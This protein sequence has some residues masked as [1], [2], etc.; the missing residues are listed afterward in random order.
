MFQKKFLIISSLI[1]VT[2]I[3]CKWF[4]SSR[5]A[6]TVSVKQGSVSTL[7]TFSVGINK[8]NDKVIKSADLINGDQNFKIGNA[9]FADVQVR[10]FQSEISFRAKSKAE[11]NITAKEKEG[12]KELILF[13]KAGEVV[14]S[15]K[16]LNKAENIIVYTPTTK[17]QVRGTQFK[18]VV[19]EDATTS[20]KVGEGAVEVGKANPALE[21]AL[22]S[23]EIGEKTKDK[24][25]QAM[26]KTQVIEAGKETTVTSKE[27]KDAL[28]D[29]EIQALLNSPTLKNVQSPTDTV[30][31][32]QLAK[33]LAELENKLPES[34]AVAD[35]KPAV[36]IEDSKDKADVKKEANEILI[37]TDD[38]KKTADQIKSD[39]NNQI[40]KNSKNLLDTMSKVMNKQ[41]ETLILNNGSN[42]TGIIF[43]VGNDY[44]VMTPA[45]ETKYDSS[46]VQG[47]K[48]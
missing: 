12:T 6:P 27:A 14:F 2:T 18:V 16:K 31:D 30:K 8:V 15:I 22:N 21:T 35:L 40:Q 33:E 42:V 20:I 4:G 36:K 10:G 17:S 3:S 41:T 23:D 43:Q 45:G 25:E 26:G 47:Y 44:S 1:L 34:K 7:I 19:K 29:P 28:N 37:I 38:G 13:I 9:S 5:K 39:V 24:I 48:F 46:L 11:F 32:D